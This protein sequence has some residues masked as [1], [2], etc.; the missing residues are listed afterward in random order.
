[1]AGDL[2]QRLQ[3]ALHFL[4]RAVGRA[5]LE[6]LRGT[7]ADVAR[8][9]LDVFIL[10]RSC[11]RDRFAAFDVGVRLRSTASLLSLDPVLLFFPRPGAARGKPEWR[12]REG[13][14]SEGSLAAGRADR[15]PKAALS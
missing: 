14:H 11:Q 5:R 13:R 10:A 1:M 2:M 6:Q 3:E 8:L 12:A 15:L 7:A 9:P 4:R